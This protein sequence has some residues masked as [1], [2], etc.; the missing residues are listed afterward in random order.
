MT[1]LCLS[2]LNGQTSEVP[3]ET[4]DQQA[5]NTTKL[6][7]VPPC[8]PTSKSI[9]NASKEGKGGDL[10]ECEGREG[11]ADSQSLLMEIVS[12]IATEPGADF[13]QDI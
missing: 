13:M 6:S 10:Q 9:E 3:V 12:E 1:I 7:S 11:G 4:E 5:H 2:L 8:T